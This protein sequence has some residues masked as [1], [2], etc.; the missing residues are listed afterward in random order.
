MEFLEEERMTVRSIRRSIAAVAG[1]LTGT[2]LLAVPADAAPPSEEQLA[3]FTKGKI[4]NLFKHLTA[5]QRASD[6]NGGNRASGLPGYD[7]SVDYVVGRL[8]EAVIR[9]SCRSS[10]S[11]TPRRTR[12]S[13]ASPRIRRRT[14]GE[15]TSSATGS[16]A[17]SRRAR[18][19]GR[20]SR[21][22]FAWTRRACR[23]TR[24]TAAASS[25]T[26]PACR[27]DPSPLSNAAPADSTSR[28]ST[29]RRPAPPR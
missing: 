24:R 5:L 25:V 4:K 9:R 20:C 17:E 28:S 29:P 6:A 1:V 11:C 12:S 19:P 7:A 22:I 3:E 18:R 13:S 16:T 27:P 26:S 10:T 2:M 21:L 23:R 8:T 14:S 15:R